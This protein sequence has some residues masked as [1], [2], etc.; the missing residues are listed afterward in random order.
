MVVKKDRSRVPYNRQK[1]LDGLERACYKRK[2][3]AQTMLK[4]VEET[5]EQ[6]FRK[7]EREIQSIEIGRAVAERLKRID[8][9]AYVR[10]ASVYKQF[11]DLP[12]LLDEVREVLESAP[13]DL[14]GQG[15]LFS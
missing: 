13:E 10:F 4:L 15:T 2:I 3:S 8:Q 6:L 9:V 1:I 14:P 7:H 12:D 5:E 11:K